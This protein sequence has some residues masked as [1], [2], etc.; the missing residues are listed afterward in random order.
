MERVPNLE[1]WSKLSVE[2]VNRR[3]FNLVKRVINTPVWGKITGKKELPERGL[4]HSWTGGVRYRQ[5]DQVYP[6]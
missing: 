4:R 3:K 5:G 6:H 1:P 2:D